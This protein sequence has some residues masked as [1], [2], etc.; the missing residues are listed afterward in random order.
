MAHLPG[1]LVSAKNRIIENS[2]LTMDKIIMPIT[3]QYIKIASSDFPDIMTWEEANAA[4]KAL[5]KGWRLP[6][7][8][9]LEVIG[10]HLEEIGG[11]CNIDGLYFDKRA[12]QKY[13]SST[14]YKDHERYAVAIFTDKSMKFF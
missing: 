9:E 6:T 10:K 2:L 5:G 12:H 14:K 13:W 7:I 1:S 3:G 11:F 8:D 4:C